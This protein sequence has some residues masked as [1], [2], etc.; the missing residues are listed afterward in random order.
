MKEKVVFADLSFPS[1]K[2]LLIVQNF[3]SHLKSEFKYRTSVEKE[4]YLTQS[5][6]RSPH[7]NRKFNNQLT[8]K[9][10]PKSSD[11]TTIADRLRAVSWSNNSYPTGMVKPVYGY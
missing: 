11:Y 10:P 9:T 5:Y 6:D 8:T 2:F 4:G 3:Q 1:S 7:A